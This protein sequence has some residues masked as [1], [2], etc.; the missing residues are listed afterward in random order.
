MHRSHE[1]AFGG[2]RAIKQASFRLLPIPFAGIAARRR[3]MIESAA[4]RLQ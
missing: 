1:A 3:R 2:E 4:G